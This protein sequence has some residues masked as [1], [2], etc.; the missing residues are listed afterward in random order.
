M[1][2]LPNLWDTGFS[3]YTDPPGECL[4]FRLHVNAGPPGGDYE[5]IVRHPVVEYTYPALV[6]ME[7]APFD[8]ARFKMGGSDRKMTKSNAWWCTQ[9]AHPNWDQERFPKTHICTPPLLCGRQDSG[10]PLICSD[11]NVDYVYTLSSH[12]IQDYKNPKL[13]EGWIRG[14]RFFSRGFRD[15][16]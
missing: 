13:C 6:A 1:T 4:P 10:A 15:V 14:E 2:A 3:C 16:T 5:R 8:Y 9:E 7:R 12:Y 11:N